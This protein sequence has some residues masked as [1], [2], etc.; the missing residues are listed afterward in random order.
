MSLVVGGLPPFDGTTAVLPDARANLGAQQ[1]DIAARVPTPSDD[2]AHGYSTCTAATFSTSSA[3]FW[4]YGRTLLRQISSITGAAEWVTY[5]P[6]GSPLPVNAAAGAYGAWGTKRLNSAYSGNLLQVTR[7]SDSTTLDL[8]Q[9]SDG[10]LN[11]APLYAF[12]LGTAYA[13]SKAYDQVG[14]NDAVQATFANMPTLL[15][16]ADGTPHISFHGA[17]VQKLVASGVSLTQNSLSIAAL[18]RNRGNIQQGTNIAFIGN[19]TNSADLHGNSA[20]SWSLSSGGN[21]LQSIGFLANRD[22]VLIGA[23]GGSASSFSIDGYGAIQSNVAAS[24]TLT[25]MTLGANNATAANNGN[26]DLLG[27]VV[28]N[29]YL[30]GTDQMNVRAAFHAGANTSPQARCKIM[31]VGESVWAGSNGTTAA[32]APYGIIDHL[33]TLLPSSAIV[34]GR[35]LGG[36][37][38]GPISLANSQLQLYAGGTY[39]SVFDSSA[40]CNVALINGGD[41]NNVDANTYNTTQVQADI[42]TLTGLLQ[43]T[44]FKVGIATGIDRADNTGLYEP[45]LA[46]MNIWMRANVGQGL[47]PNAFLIDVAADPLL[48]A[49]GAANNTALFASDKIHPINPGHQAIAARIAQALIA[50]KVITY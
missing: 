31:L 49:A 28:F 30:S 39:S 21:I 3:C 16:D 19:G 24:N 20:G 42:V 47:L 25:G 17:V 22:A 34:I 43:A 32:D 9:L 40:A 14:A 6:S 38:I 1:A 50:N 4:K 2:A 33:R 5:N 23:F 44:G 37:S 10:S 35:A 13:I 45:Y 8:G 36:Q 15:I 18:A 26:V 12:G 27:V 48:G 41:T 7:S 11:V 29:T 46:A